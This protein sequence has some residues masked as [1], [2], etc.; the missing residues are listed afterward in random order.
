SGF[1]APLEEIIKTSHDYDA[2]VLVNAV[3]SFPHQPI[4]VRKLNID[5]LVG[6]F[7]NACGP[8]GVGVLY[9]KGET[10]LNLKPVLVGG[11]S[12]TLSDGKE[13]W[14][15]PPTVFEVGSSNV[16]G[17]IG[18]GEAI[19]YLQK[20]GQPQIHKTVQSLTKKFIKSIKSYPELKLA[21]S[22]N[23]EDR[24][25]I[26]SFSID[27]MNMHEVSMLLDELRNIYVRSGYQSAY[28]YHK[29]SDMKEGSLRASWYFYNTEGEIKIF[30]ETLEEILSMYN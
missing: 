20:I 9:G 5:F 26:G 16:A 25:P 10:L 21:G 4:D 1:K 11:Q 28:G 22:F 29:D 13:I 15:K 24:G 30:M 6:N 2:L 8:T 17:I 7:Q 23:W 27:G 19:K 12:R 3:Q 18:A 14:M